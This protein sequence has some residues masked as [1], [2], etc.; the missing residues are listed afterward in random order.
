S[1]TVYSNTSGYPTSIDHSPDPHDKTI[2]RA[3]TTS[4]VAYRGTT[5]PTHRLSEGPPTHP[6]TTRLPPPDSGYTTTHSLTS[7]PH[8]SPWVTSPSEYPIPRPSLD[9]RAAAAALEAEVAWLRSQKAEKDR[10]IMRVGER[11][12]SLLSE[13]EDARIVNEKLRRSLEEMGRRV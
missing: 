6:A 5:T 10:E 13:L 1:S 4:G 2:K 11:E 8:P 7:L 3:K 9:E 12:S